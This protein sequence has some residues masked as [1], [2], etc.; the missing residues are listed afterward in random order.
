M[1]YL[2]PLLFLIPAC[3]QA[4]EWTKAD[5]AREAAYLAFHIADWGQTHNLIHRREKE[6][7]WETNR[8]L[9]K[10]PSIKRVDSYMA[11]TMLAHIGISYILPRGWREAFQY[12]TTGI[13]AGVVIHNNSVGLK[14]M[15]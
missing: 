15:F 4:D 14:V 2:L 1:K 3:C 9:G 13:E 7:Y 11:F 12:T 5:T 10:T 6:G 8:I